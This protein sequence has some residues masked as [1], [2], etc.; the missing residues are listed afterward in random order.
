MIEKMALLAQAPVAGAPANPLAI[1][2]PFIMM[3]GV[4][5]FLIWRPQQ[6]HRQ[7]LK[8]L[9][10]ELKKGDKIITSGGVIGT[11]TSIQAD[12][13]V[14]KVGGNESTKMEILKSSITGLRQ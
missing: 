2:F 14:M 5:Y 7:Q 4:M 1:L 3:F 8:K 13:I 9:V 12:Y 11:V 6:K 10:D